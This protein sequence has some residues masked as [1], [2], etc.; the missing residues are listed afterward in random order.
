MAAYSFSSAYPTPQHARAAERVTRFFSGQAGV[1]AVLL[2]C[3]C[4]R[5]KASRDSCLDLAVL[6]PD[7]RARL[8]AAWKDEFTSHPAYAEVKAV[9]LY[10]QVEVDIRDGQFHPEGHGYTSGPD[11]FELEIGNLLA[12][13]VPLWE[14]GATYRRLQQAWLPYYGQDLRLQRLNMVRGFFYNN[15]DHIPP[16]IGRG[17][18]FQAFSRFYHALGEFLQALFISRATYPIAYDKWVREQVVEILGLP[19]LYQDLPGLLEIAHFESDEITHKALRLRELF[20][21]YISA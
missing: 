21:G 10:S 16:Y 2:T 15:L 17:L 6:L 20:D 5:G 3:S 19:E 14:G 11:S 7:E 12:Y 13:S 1:E 8:E 18:Y 9:G 4:A